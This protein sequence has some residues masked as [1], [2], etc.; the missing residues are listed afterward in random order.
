MLTHNE[1]QTLKSE[2]NNLSDAFDRI[3][4]SVELFKDVLQL[5]ATV[6]AIIAFIHF[7]L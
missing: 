1:L 7:I 5:T 6:V 4:R 2:E 3:N